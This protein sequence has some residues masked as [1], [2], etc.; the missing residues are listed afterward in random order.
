MVIIIS[1]ATHT[2]K[3]VL[4]D[5]LLKKYH[6]PVLSQDLLKMGLIRSGN[7]N[8]TPDDD[9]EMTPYLWGIV[10][11]MIKTAVE[12]NQ[13]LIVEGCYVP[14]DWEADFE[15]RYLK[16]IRCVF[17]VFSENYIRNNMA[18][19]KKHADDIEKRLD[20]SHIS[21]DYLVSENEFY[22][23]GCKESGTEYILIDS[24]YTAVEEYF[25]RTF[26]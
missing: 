26:L 24:D 14:F 22:L 12:N 15:E 5:R 11:E 21:V 23:D 4:A 2:G 18:K 6:Y 17:L 1:G 7:T 25:E 3:T 8:L 9:R 19:I 10:R 13:N 16:E 20:D